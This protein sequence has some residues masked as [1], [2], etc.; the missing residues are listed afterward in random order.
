M[1]YQRGMIR[2]LAYEAIVVGEGNYIEVDDD[3]YCF[4]G[5]HSTNGFNLYKNDKLL[6]TEDPAKPRDRHIHRGLVM[7]KIDGSLYVPHTTKSQGKIKCDTIFMFPNHQGK[8]YGKLDKGWQCYM[9][10]NRDMPLPGEVRKILTQKYGV[11]VDY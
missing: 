6:K 11:V 3:K 5:Q 1:D 8:S 7:Y 10:K 2:A 4:K 9:L